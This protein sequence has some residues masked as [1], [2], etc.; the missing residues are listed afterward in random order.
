MT[1][2]PLKG[3]VF[4]KDGTLTDYHATWTPLN[5]AAAE[6]AAHGDIALTEHL[7][8]LG[9]QDP[10]TG[11]VRGGTLL[12]A[13]DTREIADA[14]VA[15]GARHD[16]RALERDMD[17]IFE[18]GARKAV[19]VTDIGALFR[20]LQARGLRVGV[21]TSDSDAA[22][23]ATLEGLGVD[24][25][26]VF[27]AGYDSGYGR[28]PTPGMVQGFCTT[29]DIVAAD[30]AVVGDNLHDIRMGRSAGCRL[31]IGVL[32]GASQHAELATEADRVL[33]SVAD[34]E[35]L[36]DGLGEAS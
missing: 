29:L 4:D 9:G 12:A 23:R 20:R 27:V 2:I 26:D 17:A 15:A 3:I 32:T 11:R 31:C 16:A 19:P 30:V 10:A 22:A 33:D 28:K 35:E 34:L 14:W 13:A 18:A 36:L 5:R 24:A 6:R 7:L 25:A 1:D 21:A 8:E